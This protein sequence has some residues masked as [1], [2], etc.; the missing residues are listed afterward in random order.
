MG[1]LVGAILRQKDTLKG[2]LSLRV[3]A[4][5]YHPG[6]W[7]LVTG[8]LMHFVLPQ[9]VS[10][11]TIPIYL[12][13]PA[14][15][16]HPWGWVPVMDPIPRQHAMSF[17]TLLRAIHQ[18]AAPSE[19]SSKMIEGIQCTT[20]QPL[21][22]PLLLVGL[23]IPQSCHRPPRRQF[24][25]R[26]SGKLVRSDGRN[27]EGLHAPSVKTLSQRSITLSVCIHLHLCISFPSR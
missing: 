26:S 1:S 16:S 20:L 13:V 10:L 21:L 19:V 22:H 7:M 5:A 6:Q 12:G 27:Q 9:Q 14:V 15:A 11:K 24:Q 8:L 4:V 18:L 25:P 17:R 2:L 23:V 3:S